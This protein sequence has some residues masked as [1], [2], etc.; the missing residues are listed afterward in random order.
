MANGSERQDVSTNPF[1]TIVLQK[2]KEWKEA[3][4]LRVKSLEDTLL[5]RE[6]DLKKEKLR[7]R[8]LKEDFEYNLKL[9]EERDAELEKYD[10][11]FGKVK[12]AEHTRAAEVSELLVKVD[13]L[14][15]KVDNEVR[16]KEELQK[17]YQKR[18][19]EYQ[20]EMNKFRQM[21]ENEI[22]QE[23]EELT[24]YRRKLESQL[25]EA[26]DDFEFRRQELV[27][28]FDEVM[29]KRE[30]EYRMKVDETSGILLANDLK[31]RTLTKELELVRSA[32]GRCKDELEKT[33]VSSRELEKE[34]KEKEWLMS[35]LQ[36]TQ[37]YR[38]SDM[39]AQMENMKSQQTKLQEDF[40]RKHAEFDRLA[41]EKEEML[42]NAKK[43]FLEQEKQLVEKIR[44]LQSQ[45]EAKA[46]E[47]RQKEWRLT[48][49][50]KEN[51]VTIQ[52]L[53]ESLADSQ[54]KLESQ[55]QDSARSTVAKDV[56]LEALQQQE[57]KLR[58]ELVQRKDELMRRQRELTLSLEREASLERS[59]TQLELDWQRRCEDAERVGYEKQEELVRNLT[60]GKEEAL[61][62]VKQQK[63]DLLHKDS[64]I[65]ILTAQR[66]ESMATLKRHGFSVPAQIPTR[67]TFPSVD[68]IN[69]PEADEISELR[70]QNEN[71]MQI[72]H[73]MRKDM[74]D[75][76][77][78]LSDRQ[79]VRDSK[80][81]TG[82]PITTEYVE[83]LEKEV[84]DLKSKNRDLTHSLTSGQDHEKAN[85]P[86]PITSGKKSDPYVK[87]HVKEL[88][89]TIGSLRQE[90][91][92]LTSQMR[93]CEATIMHLQGIFNQSTEEV[94]QKQVAIE[95]LKYQLTTQSRRTEEELTSWKQRNAD[96]SL[97]LSQARHEADEFYKN[98]LERN[99][100]A[101][102]LG[103]QLSALK[104]DLATQ[105]KT[106][107]SYNPQAHLVRQLQDEIQ[108]LRLQLKKDM[109][110][111]KGVRSMSSANVRQL[112]SKLRE[113]AE[114][115]NVLV[116]EREQLIKMGN[117]LRAELMKFKGNT[118]STPR[119]GATETQ[120]SPKPLPKPHISNLRAL[121]Q[122][123]YQLTAR[124][125][126]YAQRAVV[127]HGEPRTKASDGDQL[128]GPP[129][130]NSTIPP[131]R[132]TETAL[133]GNRG[134]SSSHD[135]KLVSP[136]QP[137]FSSNDR[138][139]LQE[140]WKLLDEDSPAITPR[141]FRED[142]EV[143]GPLK[144]SRPAGSSS[145]SESFTVKGRPTGMQ[146][147]PA[148]DKRMLSTKAAGKWK[149][150]QQKAHVRNYN[151]K[152][153]DIST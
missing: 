153:N 40:S 144:S 116:K 77:T 67:D 82:A 86:I 119:Q 27:S 132:E 26:E 46:Q 16:A 134:S 87:G 103:N 104:M 143:S 100:D 111:E 8:K 70:G 37:Q 118:N 66:D 93:K 96:L 117:K 140:V 48:D 28:D 99:T 68:E 138:S 52:R 130:P 7:F 62:L 29:R 3:F 39:E 113:A 126:Q 74:E 139:S 50:L 98:S 75:L 20:N 79:A 12:Q 101:V 33:E 38:I 10:A 24:T 45:L 81:D 137:S 112:Q 5:E 94:R 149:P 64:L 54:S 47:Y 133:Q 72:I 90:K 141:V 71:L 56:E 78:Q 6:K 128:L 34:L 61:S 41:R 92:E 115:I 89:D 145:T 114:R 11:V 123:Q 85:E 106:V 21:K 73:Q 32:S 58:T 147:K 2:E 42:A 146:P 95:Q 44:E 43:G 150:S 76:T 31:I 83:S 135:E 4:L 23:R 125:L 18:L 152:D 14:K 108:T 107:G 88:N 51:E 97:Q 19:Q 49:K 53:E 109:L 120:T 60:Q 1:D 151:I 91:L 121:E 25:R 35:D 148:A 15:L 30:Q 59:K 122:L 136:W 142:E 84:R 55:T 131:K 36:N 102:S 65:R 127:R 17:H 9:I 13:E 105:G 69:V 124:E 129:R 80:T 63:R 22:N 110:S 57:G